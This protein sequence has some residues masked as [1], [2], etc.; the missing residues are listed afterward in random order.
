[1]ILP[2]LRNTP[3]GRVNLAVIFLGESIK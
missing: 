1:L 2:L 3:K